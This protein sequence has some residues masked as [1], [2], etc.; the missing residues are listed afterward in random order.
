[1]AIDYIKASPNAISRVERF[2]KKLT[3]K[4]AG[5]D[6]NEF[7]KQLEKLKDVNVFDFD[8]EFNSLMSQY[9]D[10]ISGFKQLFQY[11]YPFSKFILHFLNG[12]Y[13]QHRKKVIITK[14]QFALEHHVVKLN[15]EIN[16]NINL[17]LDGWRKFVQHNET[18][19]DQKR[20][21]AITE[22]GIKKAEKRRIINSDNQVIFSK[23][24]IKMAQG[25]VTRID[26]QTEI[27][28]KIKMFFEFCRKVTLEMSGMPRE[29]ASQPNLVSRSP[30]HS[31]TT[32]PVV[33]NDN[34]HHDYQV[35][36]NLHNIS[37]FQGC[38][39]KLQTNRNA[40]LDHLKQ[41]LRIHT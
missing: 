31:S 2:A 39:S 16:L 37:E 7:I 41:L 13:D 34:L 18:L 40:H 22:D 10:Q 30:L 24:F 28:K 15:T 6:T 1:M 5:F 25:L 4:Q 33:F 14:L 12:C 27:D 32:I 20:N 11:R 38:I 19:I 23:N 36:F 8:M 21:S 3:I 17:W 26:E 35:E 29:N 9:G